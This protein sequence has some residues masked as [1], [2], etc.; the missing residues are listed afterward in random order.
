MKPYKIA[1]AAA[2]LLLASATSTA[3]EWIDTYE[4]DELMTYGVRLGFN[5]SNATRS[6]KGAIS[7]LDSWGTGFDVGAVVS[8]NFNN[9]VSLQPG[10]FF[11]SRS[12]NYSYIMPW[13]SVTDNM[14][15]V[16]EYGHT[17]YTSFQMPVM[18]VLKL[19]PAENLVWSLECGPYL[20]FGLGGSD[21]GTQDAGEQSRKYSD[22]Y[23]DHRKKFDFGFK[24]G[25]GIQFLDHYYIGIHYEAGCCSV[26]KYYGGK[27][28]AW[29]FTLGYDF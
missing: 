2:M 13:P 1:S 10:F 24:M 21:K 25:S 19:R 9:A 12:H 27:N 7:S 23:F 28:K 17:R 3:Q 5:T 4:A 16:H 15:N 6:T 29:T 14:P 20:N 26:W 11:Q 22:G 18:G 8:L